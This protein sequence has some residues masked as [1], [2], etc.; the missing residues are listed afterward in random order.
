[1]N[2]FL[3][4]LKLN[5]RT[6][7]K[8]R[9]HLLTHGTAEQVAERLTKLIAPRG[10]VTAADNWMPQGFKDVKEAQL[11]NAEVLLDVNPYGKT[12]KSW[13]LAVA[14]PVVVTP[15]WGKHLHH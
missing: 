7:S 12:L 4:N 6:G 5:Q 3:Q 14:G 13:W 15:N 8:P 10:L 2:N 9:C 11:H 1:M